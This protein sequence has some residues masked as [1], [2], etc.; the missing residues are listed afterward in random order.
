MVFRDDIIA[1]KKLKYFE[2][3]GEVFPDGEKSLKRKAKSK[4]KNIEMTCSAPTRKS[5]RISSSSPINYK[6]Q[7]LD[8]KKQQQKI[9]KFRSPE[10][11]SSEDKSE[12]CLKYC[13]ICK[14]SF[15]TV[16]ILRNHLNKSHV[17]MLFNCP[18]CELPMYS[19]DNLKKHFKL[20]HK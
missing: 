13:G 5:S 19:K 12:K 17:R 8:R 9:S 4:N 1:E 20:N 11:T 15:K 6:E 7:T 16:D 10:E 3:T 18:I 2:C 14:A